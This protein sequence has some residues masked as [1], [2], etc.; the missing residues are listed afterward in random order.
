MDIKLFLKHFYFFLINKHFS[1]NIEEIN[2]PRNVY[3]KYI[4]LSLLKIFFI[5]ILFDR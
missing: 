4:Q 3:Q 2:I 1:K 5:L